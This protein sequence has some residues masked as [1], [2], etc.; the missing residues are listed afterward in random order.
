MHEISA[1]QL[2]IAASKTTLAHDS[3]VFLQNRNSMTRVA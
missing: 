2:Q 3:L 1:D